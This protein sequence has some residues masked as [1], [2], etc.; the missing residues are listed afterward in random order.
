[1]AF[2]WEVKLS[3]LKFSVDGV[4][5]KHRLYTVFTILDVRTQMTFCLHIMF[6]EC[7]NLGVLHPLVRW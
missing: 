6:S 7:Q 4:C 2:A 1:M 3:L 5:M